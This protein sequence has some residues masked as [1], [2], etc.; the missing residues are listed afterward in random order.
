MTTWTTHRDETE[1]DGS[2]EDSSAQLDVIQGRVVSSRAPEDPFPQVITPTAIRSGAYAHPHQILDPLAVSRLMGTPARA[3][4]RWL[5][6]V[7]DLFGHAADNHI[8]PAAG[9]LTMAGVSVWAHSQPYHPLIG[10]S[11]ITV[12]AYLIRAGIKAHRHHGN[13]AD[14]VFTKGLL[15]AGATLALVG[16]GATVG[17][18]PWMAVAVALGTGVAYTGWHQWQHHKTERAREFAV[19]L[20]AAGNT[21]PAPLP[22]VAWAP[23]ALPQSDEEFRLTAAFAKI[24]AGGVILSPVRRVNDDVWYVF[25]DL[26]ETDAT[27]EQVETQAAKIAT[28]MRARRVE[29]E[30]GNRPSLIKVTVHDGED[31]LDQ[32]LP[33]P[34]PRITSILEPVPLGLLEDGTEITLSMAWGHTLVAGTTDGGKSGVVN[35]ILLGTLGC[36][37]LVRILTDCKAGAPE[38]R[39][40]KDIAFNVASGPEE[41]MRTLAGLKAVYEYRGNLLVEK[42]VPAEL[43]EDGETVRKWKPEYGPFILAAIDELAE[44]TRNVKGSA[45]VVQSLRA[46]MR[47]V[48]MF[49]LDA[50]Q[51]PSRSVFDD[52]TD[53]RLNYR[54]RVGLQTMETTATNIILGPR[55]HGLGWRLD[56]LNLPGKMM[57]YS[58]EHRRPRVSRAYL[59]TDQDIA[60]AVAQFRGKVVEMDEGSAQAFWEGYNAELDID[61]TGGGGPRGGGQPQDAAP[62]GTAYSRGGTT[63]YAIE[64]Y[65]GTSIPVEKKY[66]ALWHLLAEQREPISAPDLAARAE[67]RGHVDNSESWVRKPLRYWLAEGWIEM[68]MR[69]G[70]KYFWRPDVLDWRAD[71]AAS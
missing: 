17:L 24:N 50:T 23:G 16:T 29:I 30:P 1:I 12:G 68:E 27:A 71:G 51:N 25:A 15:G 4:P 66:L 5:T 59:I 55:M 8:L 57:V 21:G 33:W 39:A 47:F 52:S 56:L 6:G 18:S 20:T 53:A 45:K 49:A 28:R 65:P 22:P 19:A 69:S 43:D 61:S 32:D 62:A 10:G 3:T 31:P 48:G 44:L 63:L 64:T 41:G 26:A 42:D 13:D 34:G 7:K 54:N 36:T 2:T 38:F 37:D 40:Y 9:V 67:S 70:T 14:P 35:A 60:R 11:I 46:T 58:R